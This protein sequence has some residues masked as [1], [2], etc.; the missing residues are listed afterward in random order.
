MLLA[1]TLLHGSSPTT[2]LLGSVLGAVVT[3]FTHVLTWGPKLLLFLNPGGRISRTVGTLAQDT[4]VL[5][6]LV[7]TTERPDIA[8]ALSGPVLLFGLLFGGP[9]HHLARFGVTLFKSRVWAFVSHSGWRE[10]PELPSW[11]RPLQE[12]AETLSMRGTPA[13]VVG[14]PGIRGFREGWFLEAGEERAFVFRRRG[15][16]RVVHLER[17]SMGSAE[18]LELVLRVPLDVP[19]RKRSA[20]FLQRDVLALKRHK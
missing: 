6:F 10:G 8:F 7:L 14:L 3:A 4:G 9:A 17:G 11:I 12:G 13:G 15:K 19:G 20:L 1:L 2:L 5:V 18:R 16:A